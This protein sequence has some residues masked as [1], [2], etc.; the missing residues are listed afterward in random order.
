LAT[1]AATKAYVLSLSESL[2]EE[3]RDSGVSVTALC[4]GITATAML[5]R[6]TAHNGKLAELPGFLVGEVEAVAAEGYRAC[7]AG[8]VIT[9]PG[10][11]NR[12][13]TLAAGATPKWLVRR[14]AGVLGRRVI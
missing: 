10:A 1:Y 6:A 12:A 2:A 7:L 13:A 4:P 5:G 9:V 14:V 8:E 3:L 11:L